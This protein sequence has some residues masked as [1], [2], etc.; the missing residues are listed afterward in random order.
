MPGKIHAKTQAKAK[1]RKARRLHLKLTL[2]PGALFDQRGID[3]Q[4][5]ACRIPRQKN[6]VFL[7]RMIIQVLTQPT[8][9]SK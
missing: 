1:Q 6:S 4:K 7:D 8:K 9:A 2:Q 3:C 5:R